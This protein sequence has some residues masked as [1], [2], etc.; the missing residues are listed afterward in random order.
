MGNRWKHFKTV[1]K[2]KAVVFKECKSC[3]ITWQGVIH[4]LS[5]F[6]HIEFAP[7]AEYFQ[8]TGSPIEREKAAKG[9]SIAW[10]NHKGRNKH[11]WEWW[12]DFAND[13]TI[14]ANKIPKK[15]VAEMLCDWI[16]AGKV[17]QKEM[18]TRADPL[19]YYNKVR[20][21]RH[22]HSDTETMLVMFLEVIRDCGLNE[23]HKCIRAWLK[24][25]EDNYVIADVRN[26]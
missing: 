3:G 25:G 8:G 5:K 21:G 26:G 20:A 10:L 1:C 23:Y 12:T 17:Y 11:H 9:Y 7:S 4:D 15:Y 18:W 22:F 13:G 24:T 19:N 2:H 6:S 16:G 14:I